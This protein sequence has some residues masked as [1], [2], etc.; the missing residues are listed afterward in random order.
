MDAALRGLD[1][2]EKP[3]DGG[4]SSSR[5]GLGKRDSSGHPALSRGRSEAKRTRL[6]DV[7]VEAAED[8]DDSSS[9]LEGERPE[10]PD[11]HPRPVGQ[12]LAFAPACGAHD[13]NGNGGG[14]NVVPTELP[15]ADAAVGAPQQ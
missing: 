8:D 2:E 6:T 10:K 13:A 15:P 1:S 9:T 11:E 14:T 4:D 7:T 3:D 5:R 12:P